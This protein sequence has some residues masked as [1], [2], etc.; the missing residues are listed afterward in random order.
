MPFQLAVLKTQRSLVH[1]IQDRK[2]AELLCPDFQNHGNDFLHF[3]RANHYWYG[4]GL[5]VLTSLKSGNLD[6]VSSVG[7]LEHR[8]KKHFLETSVLFAVVDDSHRRSGIPKL[9]TLVQPRAERALR[10]I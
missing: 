9:A 6:A 5:I 8:G 10:P 7:M 4:A 1:S 3:V 2:S